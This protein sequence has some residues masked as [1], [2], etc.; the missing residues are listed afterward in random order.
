M[1]L[2]PQ[3]L[4]IDQFIP[5]LRVIELLIRID[6]LTDQVTPTNVSYQLIGRYCDNCLQLVLYDI[7]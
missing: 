5:L 6:G 2:Y 3:I 7:N 4:G 1:V